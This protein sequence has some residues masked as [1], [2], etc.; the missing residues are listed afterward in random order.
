VKV[1]FA[2]AYAAGLQGL[3]AIAEF[4]CDVVSV[5]V[6]KVQATTGATVGQFARSKGYRVDSGKQVKSAEFADYLRGCGVDL[7]I[8]VLSPFWVCPEVLSA[9]RIGS[10][11]LHPSLLPRHA[12]LSPMAWALYSGDTEHGVTLHWMDPTIDTGA[13]VYQHKLPIEP[14]DNAVSMLRACVRSGIPMITDL[15]RIATDN[16]HQIPRKPQDQSHRSYH[17]QQ[18]PGGGKID[19]NKTAR[20]VR[21]LARG[22]DYAPL[23]AP[24]GPLLAEIGGRQVEVSQICMTGKSC[25]GHIPGS[26]A[27]EGLNPGSAMIATADEWILASFLN[28]REMKMDQIP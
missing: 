25:E 12:G 16:P 19:W 23:R 21:C 13:I 9:P 5:L 4:G 6:L 15:L 17:G 22:Y 18:A 3:R 1:V 2:G 26:A 8:N 20:E 28:S 24:W 14:T 7:F 10:F 27:P 11:N